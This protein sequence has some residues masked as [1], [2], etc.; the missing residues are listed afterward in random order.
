MQ[1]SL[2]PS[3]ACMRLMPSSAA[4]PEPGIALV[5]ICDRTCRGNKCSGC[6]A[7]RCRRGSPCCAFARSPP[8]AAT[9][10]S[11][12]S[13][14]GHPDDR[15]RRPCAPARRAAGRCRC[16]S[17]R[18]GSVAERVDI[19]DA[20]GPHDVELHQIDKRGAAGQILTASNAPRQPLHPRHDM[21]NMPTQIIS[22]RKLR[23]AACHA[24][25]ILVLACLIAATMFG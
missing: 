19:D 2:T 23:M 21:P 14:G 13:R 9:A 22:A 15:R 11:P 20:V 7:A 6:A 3:T 4:Q 25:F 1:C 16:D 24:S 10:R 18:P 5:A 17:I 12:E 8:V